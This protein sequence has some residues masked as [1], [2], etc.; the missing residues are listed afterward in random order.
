VNHTA[1]LKVGKGESPAAAAAKEIGI[2]ALAT[3]PTGLAVKSI[4]GATVEK[5]DLKLSDF[6]E[7]LPGSSVVVPVGG[8]AK[9]SVG[10]SL[11]TA[12]AENKP[13]SPLSATV[14][15]ES[16]VKTTTT[17]P[18]RRRRVFPK[19]N[20]NPDAPE[21]VDVENMKSS[22]SV[23]HGTMAAARRAQRPD[24]PADSLNVGGGGEAVKNG[25]VTWVKAESGGGERNGLP[26]V[27]GRNGYSRNLAEE[28]EE[29]KKTKSPMKGKS[30]VKAMVQ[31]LL[32]YVPF[33]IMVEGGDR[34]QVGYQ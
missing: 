28:G 27:E 21:V 17:T 7:T 29:E 26:A 20:D 24:V 12:I 30:E 23:G 9:I 34:V 14:T 10:S 25:V 8:I 1:S 2:T 22:L 33:Q 13:D 3:T 18:S 4:V 31:V 32:S 11:E 15:E 19:L 16:A 5:L 6:P